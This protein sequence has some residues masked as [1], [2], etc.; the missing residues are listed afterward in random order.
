MWEL[1]PPDRQADAIEFATTNL[2]GMR[3]AAGTIPLRSVLRVT[4]ARRLD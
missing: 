3:D 2:N 1:I 4:T